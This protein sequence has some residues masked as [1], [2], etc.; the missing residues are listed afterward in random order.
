[1]EGEAMV[2]S[3][4]PKQRAEDAMHVASNGID[5]V[6][7]VTNEC[8]EQTASMLDRFI[9]GV[10]QASDAFDRQAAEVRDRSL[11]IAKETLTNSMEFAQRVTHVK[12]PQ[13]L[14]QLQSEFF[15]KQAQTLADHSRHFGQSIAQGVQQIGKVASEGLREAS[16]TTS[17]AA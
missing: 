8:L 14:F 4:I 1:M 2:K 9:S 10:G 3:S 5:W 6:R 16:R 7:Q 17:E 13:E 11:L 12:Q 15:S